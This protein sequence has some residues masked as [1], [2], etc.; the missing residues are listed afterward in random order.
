MGRS[1]DSPPR[2]KKPQ[3]KSKAAVARLK[4]EKRR[5]RNVKRGKEAPWKREGPP[6]AA[7]ESPAHAEGNFLFRA[8]KYEEALKAYSAAIDIAPDHAVLY[9][10]RSACALALEKYADALQDTEEAL[11]RD[12]TMCKAYYRRALAFRH[13]GDLRGA[14]AA[15]RRALRCPN[16]SRVPELRQE[17]ELIHQK[18]TDGCSLVD[19]RK[20]LHP[21]AKRA[22]DADGEEQDAEEEQDDRPSKRQKVLPTAK[23]ADLSKYLEPGE[24]IL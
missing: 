24:T 22:R 10:N 3:P 5:Q 16:S 6:E 20:L 19:C 1:T 11:K 17:L 2:A 13:L 12:R 15:I 14:R 8:G 23:V 21:K 4:R 9:C 18:I 7:E